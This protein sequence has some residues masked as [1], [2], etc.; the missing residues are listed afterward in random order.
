MYCCTAPA[1]IPFYFVL[2]TAFFLHVS[3]PFL[4]CFFFTKSSHLT[5][6]P[7]LLL[8]LL[9]AAPSCSRKLETSA[10]VAPPERHPLKTTEACQCEKLARSLKDVDFCLV[11]VVIGPLEYQRAAKSKELNCI[12]LNFDDLYFRYGTRN[13]ST[14][15]HVDPWCIEFI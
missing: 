11:I 7:I 2:S 14:Y 5:C 9:F 3:S 10:V 15:K 12:Q 13:K 4:S 8:L 6:P 1:F